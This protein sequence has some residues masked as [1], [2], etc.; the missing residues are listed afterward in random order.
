MTAPNQ[1]QPDPEPNARQGKGLEQAP[2]EGVS[3]QDPAEGADD[4]NPPTEGSPRG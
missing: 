1:Q 2:N 3:A 4:V